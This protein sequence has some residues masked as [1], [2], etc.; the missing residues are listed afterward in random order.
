LS[1]Q[2]KS[3]ARVNKVVGATKAFFF[4]KTGNGKLWTHKGKSS[5]LLIVSEA[6]LQ[7]SLTDPQKGLHQPSRQEEKIWKKPGGHA[8]CHNA[9]ANL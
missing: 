9:N 4:Q 2:V 6:L 3:A 5:A 7:K 8:L 1:L